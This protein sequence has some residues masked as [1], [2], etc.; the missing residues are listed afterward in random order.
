MRMETLRAAFVKLTIGFLIISI[1]LSG[2]AALLGRA[3]QPSV[4]AF[5][6]ERTG[7][8]QV[9]LLDVDH[10]LTFP[11]SQ[12]LVHNSD[13]VWS[14]AQDLAFVR[15]HV[16]GRDVVVVNPFSGR[17][18]AISGR[19]LD[20]SSPA[21]SP[22]GNLAYVVGVGG[23]YDLYVQEG[24]RGETAR[25]VTRRS[26]Y[27]VNRPHWSVAGWLAY[28]DDVNGTTQIA[29]LDA[30]TGESVII[31]QP[32]GINYNPVWFEDRLLAF[33]SIEERNP[34]I[35][36]YDLLSGE[37]RNVSS[38]PASDT[39]PAWS[40]DGRLAFTSE[41]LGRGDIFVYDFGSDS[42]TNVTRSP[43]DEI[44]PAW[45]PDGRLAFA[46]ASGTAFDIYV[47]D[48]VP[49]GTPRPVASHPSQEYSPVWM[50]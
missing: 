20:E 31:L 28:D 32:D 27:S 9:Y 3:R 8:A 15:D 4:I 48:S 17:R 36:V 39:Q 44:M 6:G 19:L 11:V 29:V 7:T 35:Y 46:S 13:P 16:N 21:W 24:C 22:D 50:P 49:G 18:C 45:S 43:A 37:L 10:M 26:S 2:G 41:R 40:P 5:V 38:H 47:L 33:V 42:I 1:T 30:R 34:E 25:V 12:N 14:S 23:R